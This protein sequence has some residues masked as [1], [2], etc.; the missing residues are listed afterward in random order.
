MGGREFTEGG[1]RGILDPIGLEEGLKSLPCE[2]RVA[3]GGKT[4]DIDSHLDL[5]FGKKG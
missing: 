1:W 4:P 5:V 2:V 3:T